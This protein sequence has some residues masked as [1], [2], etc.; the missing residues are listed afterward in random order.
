MEKKIIVITGLPGV[1]KST[2]AKSI[3]QELR[4]PVFSV[5]PIESA[6]IHSKIKKSFKTGVAAYLISEVLASEQLEVGISVVIDSVSPVQEARN[7]WNDL[8]EKYNA[9]KIIIECVLETK[10]H[11]KRINLREKHLYGFTEITWEDVLNRQKD[12][13]PW[14]EKHLILDTSQSKED[15]LEKALAYINR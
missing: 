13:L 12:Y 15:L 1:G 2:L 14:T 4:I 11:Q 7:M 9:K 3:A 10:L 5:D 8:S 6:I